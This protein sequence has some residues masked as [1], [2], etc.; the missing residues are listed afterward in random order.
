MPIYA[1]N[2]SLRIN[3]KALIDFGPR[4]KNKPKIEKK[5]NSLEVEG[6]VYKSRMAI[7]PH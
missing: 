2:I 6:L 5:Q 1:Q 4:K 7:T 3:E